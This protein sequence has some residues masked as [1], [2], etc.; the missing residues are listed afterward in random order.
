VVIELTVKPSEIDG[1]DSGVAEIGPTDM[2][3][4]NVESGDYV[5]VHGPEDKRAVVEVLPTDDAEDVVRLDEQVRSSTSLAV[6]ATATVETTRVMTAE[7]VTVALPKGFDHGDAVLS[8]RDALVGRALIEG[9]TIVLS[10][11]QANSNAST[12]MSVP[13]EIVHTTPTGVVVVQ[14]WTQI[15][16]SPQPAESLSADDV[17]TEPAGVT[18]NDIGGLDDELDRLSELL[19]FPMRH[20][21]AFERLDVPP[22]TGILLHGP[23]GAGKTLVARA[24]A[25]ELDATLTT[26]SGNDLV[27][28]RP[29]QA[30]ERITDVFDVTLDDG[31]AIVFLDDLESLSTPGQDDDRER[32]I[33]AQLQSSLDELD[34]AH[35]CTV[36]GATERIDAV[37][38]T[39]RR[40]GRFDRVVEIGAPDRDAR[41]D[42]LRVH[43]RNTPLAADVDLSSYADRTYGFVG[44]DLERLAREGAMHA[45]DR[46]RSNLDGETIDPTVLESLTVT[47]ADMQTALEDIDPVALTD[48]FVD[49]PDVAWTDIG[50]LDSVKERLQQTVQWPLEYPEAY[51]RVDLDPSTG[52]L[53]YGPPGTGKT[54]LAKAVA[55]EAQS[56]FISVKGPELFDKYV[57]E[58]ERGVRDVFNKA[59]ENA[60]AV[61]FFDE[62]DAIATERGQG[63]GDAS[64]GE[65]VVSQLLTEL[66]GLE[67]L[68]DVVVIATTNRPD[69]I[70]DALVRAGRLDRH[71]H[72]PT[73]DEAARREIFRVHTRDQPLSD[74]DLD[75]LAANSEGYV[76]A[77]I[78][79]ICREAAS[80]AIREFVG[81]D[82]NEVGD[83]VLTSDHFEQALEAVKPSAEPADHRFDEFEV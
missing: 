16:V 7:E 3:E 23:P 77:D 36:L 70:D 13:V 68:S 17:R 34:D 12:S 56:N 54:L 37:D 40:P 24:L 74:V 72:V 80:V 51:T 63:Y 14:D 49:V 28:A 42:I 67:E 43:T 25:N 1:V 8:F 30:A 11:K 6:D 44:A 57:G 64:V 19:G 32:E 50:G 18:F 55:N 38:S 48:I 21:E 75:E 76:G 83:I 15:A 20:P 62:I 65:R 2:A 60:P 81:S 41:K 9:Q 39:L 35:K 5:I 61:V 29:G 31:P 26:V 33:I 22:L 10:I 59:R 79:A 4:L 46:V 47:D 73:P 71:V 52:I 27:S 82:S 69:L 45:I 66:D 53:L 58:S 78:E